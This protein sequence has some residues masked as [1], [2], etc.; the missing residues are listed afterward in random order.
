MSEP[1]IVYAYVDLVDKNG[2]VPLSNGTTT[3]FNGT[4][5]WIQTNLLSACD[6]LGQR[7]EPV[8]GNAAVVFAVHDVHKWA[9][10]AVG[11]CQSEIR[12]VERD[13][14]VGRYILVK[15]SDAPP[16]SVLARDHGY[17]DY[18]VDIRDRLRALMDAP[19]ASQLPTPRINVPMPPVKPPRQEKS[20]RVTQEGLDFIAEIDSLVAE[21]LPPAKPAPRFVSEALLHMLG[22]T[23]PLDQCNVYHHVFAPSVS[24]KE[25]PMSEKP[26]PDPHAECKLTLRDGKIVD[27]YGRP[28]NGYAHVEPGGMCGSDLRPTFVRMMVDLHRGAPAARPPSRETTLPPI[29]LS[30]E[31]LVPVG[32]RERIASEVSAKCGGRPVVFLPNGVRVA[33]DENACT[34]CGGSGMIRDGSTDLRALP[35]TLAWFPCPKCGKQEQSVSVNISADVSDATRAFEKFGQAVSEAMKTTPARRTECDITK[36]YAEN[37]N[38]D[39]ARHP[40]KG[41]YRTLIVS[42]VFNGE[43]WRETLREVV[44]KQGA[45]PGLLPSRRDWRLFARRALVSFALLA[46]MLAVVTAP[47]WAPRATRWFREW[48]RGNVER[49]VDPHADETDAAREG[50]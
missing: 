22:A 13:G 15:S 28:L 30:S 9:A 38:A 36:D 39:P 32:E 21:N 3:H 17:L 26:A 11:V 4:R 41:D 33:L 47:R 50:K 45:D 40:D 49:A 27:D 31:Q 12:S 10:L 14:I 20:D 23:A 43:E 7:I 37:A 29:I 5:K 34:M 35:N 24:A 42:E 1:K 6:R 8:R 44:P 2:D 18:A 46:V 16:T 48:S 19:F 25:K